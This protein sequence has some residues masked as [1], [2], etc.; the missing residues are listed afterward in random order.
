[1]INA[2]TVVNSFPLPNSSKDTFITNTQAIQA[3]KGIKL[4]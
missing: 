3:A 1:M 4:I 2:R